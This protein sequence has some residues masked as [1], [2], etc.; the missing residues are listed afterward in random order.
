MAH[1]E[2]RATNGYL[3]DTSKMAKIEIYWMEMNI[4]NDNNVDFVY[5]V[6]LAV[7]DGDALASIMNSIFQFGS[8]A[9]FECTT[10][11]DRRWCKVHSTCQ[12]TILHAYTSS[13]RPARKK[14]DKNDNHFEFIVR[15]RGHVENMLLLKAERNRNEVVLRIRSGCSGCE[16]ASRTSS[17]LNAVAMKRIFLW[18]KRN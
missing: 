14:N 15:I 7:A 16:R 1:T 17:N 3:C 10:P 6:E 12:R 5:S 2:R 13:A 18:M 9:P 8:M 11:N 4:T